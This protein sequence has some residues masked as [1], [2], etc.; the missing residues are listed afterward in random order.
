MPRTPIQ[1]QQMKDERKLSIL[2]N[3]LPL[4][5][6]NGKDGVSI[7]M[8]CQR[9]KC[10]HGLIYHYFKN[11]EQIYQELLT[12]STYKSLYESL[13]SISVEENT[14][15]VFEKLTKQLQDLIK[16]SRFAVCFALIIVSDDGKKSLYSSLLKLISKGQKEGVVTGGNPV[17]I[18]DTYFL[19]FKGL[20][21]SVLNQ[22]HPK[23]RVPSIDN[24][25]KII[26]R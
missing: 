23:I 17:D 22:K 26:K 25:L 4:F 6:L 21:Q 7:D 14:Y 16:E 13:V 10:S 24:I 12:S 5:A 18:L 11:T 9:S 2:E 1:F 3:A 20:Y 15:S 19:V 8:I